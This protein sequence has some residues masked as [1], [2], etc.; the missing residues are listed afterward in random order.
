MRD[1]DDGIFTFRTR[2]DLAVFA[3]ASIVPGHSERQNFERERWTIAQ[4]FLAVVAYGKLQLPLKMEHRG[5]RID[6]AAPDFMV[7]LPDATNL[8]IEVTSA[9]TSDLQD[10][11]EKNE[12][13]ELDPKAEIWSPG[14]VGDSPERHWADIVHFFINKKLRAIS[15]GHFLAADRQELV[16]YADTGAPGADINSA[17]GKLREQLSNAA[18]PPIAFRPISIVTTYCT[19]VYDALGDW[20]ILPIPAP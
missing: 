6:G 15:K 1:T 17:L 5:Y 12:R 8:G 20:R 16:I 19:L 2:E 4:Y 11:Y 14:W 13:G 9:T 3:R 10:H 7:A 18:G